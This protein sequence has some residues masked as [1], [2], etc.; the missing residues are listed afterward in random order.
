MHVARQGVEDCEWPLFQLTGPNDLTHLQAAPATHVLLVADPQVLDHRSYPGRG[1]LL[2]RVTQ[3]IVDYNLRKSWR[4]TRAFKPQVIMVL[5]D[6]M[7]G[8]RYNMPD[9]E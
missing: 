5:G 9:Q 3:F 6:M 7:D 2:M 8:G 4:V 1:W